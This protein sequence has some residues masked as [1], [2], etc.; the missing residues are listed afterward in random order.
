M[1]SSKNRDGRA[2]G[3]S[4]VRTERVADDAPARSAA[5]WLGGLALALYFAWVLAVSFRPMANN[6]FWL[7]LSVGE[8]VL[9]TGQIPEADSWSATAAGRPYFAHGW[10]SG[11]IYAWLHGIGPFAVT[12]WRAA[13]ALA[14]AGLMVLAL[15]ARARRGAFALPLLVVATYVIAY[16]L[17]VRPHLA[18][19]LCFAALVLALE[20][21]RVHRSWKR[22]AWL[23]V[24]FAL[25]ANLH[26]GFLYGLGVLGLFTVGVALQVA[27]EAKRGSKRLASEGFEWADVKQ[28]ALL[29]GACTLATLLNP[30]G[31]RAL[32]FPITMAEGNAF[33]K[34]F[35]TEWESPFTASFREGNA[36]VFVAYVLFLVAAWV[37][38]LLTLSR[39]IPLDFLLLLTVSVMSARANR[40]LPYLPLVGLPIAVRAWTELSAARG[41]SWARRRVWLELAAIGALLFAAVQFG[42]AHGPSRLRPT[43]IGYG[44]SMPYAEVARMKELGLE[45]VVFN[46]L[47]DGAL[48]IHELGPAVKPV[49]DARVDVYGRELYEEYRAS[50]ETPPAFLAYVERHRVELV[51]VYTQRELMAAFLTQHPDWEPVFRT[52]THVL[53]ARRR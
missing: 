51:F 25:W 13:L 31:L 41:W 46:E 35:I 40:F 27:L 32:L 17:S 26:G 15:P 43:G 2:R 50:R 18:S 5:A 20:G 45:G 53:F 37:P 24:L 14:I 7:H 19:L 52:G 48:L 12:L 44:G 9:R 29:T 39:R 38:V 42:F 21:W 30:F 3:K 1:S 47:A 28:L 34:E 23:P 11:V 36:F 16:R 10:L 33:L 49:M 4:K 8:Q 22:C 6:D